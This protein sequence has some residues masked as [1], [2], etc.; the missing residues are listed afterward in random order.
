MEPSTPP[1]PATVDHL[2]RREQPR[3]PAEFEILIVGIVRRFL[4]KLFGDDEGLTA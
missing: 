2:L 1:L 4:V 3:R